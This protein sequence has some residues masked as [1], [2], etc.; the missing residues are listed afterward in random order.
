[1]KTIDPWAEQATLDTAV[2]NGAIFTHA[3]T[4]WKFKVRYVAPWSKYVGRAAALVYSRPDVAA[5]NKMRISGET[6]SPEDEKILDRAEIEV[7][8]RATFIGW[9]KTVTGRDRKP[10]PFNVENA[11]MIAEGLPQ[12]WQDIQRFSVNAA[13]FGLG[14]VPETSVPEGVDAS[15]NSS[16]TSD[17]QSEDSTS[18]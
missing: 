15:G 16:A 8:V 4:G 17:S 7:N 6:L 11:V 13:N 18:S 10:L 5:A 14:R 1:M 9:S 12:V 3:R 2:E